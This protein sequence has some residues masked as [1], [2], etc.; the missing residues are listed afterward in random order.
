MRGTFSILVTMLICIVVFVLYFFLGKGQINKQISEV[1]AENRSQLER[2]R[3]IDVMAAELPI[4]M[5]QLP[6]WKNQLALYKQ[7]IPGPVLDN[8]FLSM[9]AYQL[10]AQDVMLL[11]VEVV[12]E[13]KWL[14]EI[15]EQQ[16]EELRAK[17]MC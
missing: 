1:K 17:G 13:G 10:E 12:P 9:L 7:A 2:L 16:E 3:E 5:Q 6:R 15:G 11:T 8:Q 4:L 14:G